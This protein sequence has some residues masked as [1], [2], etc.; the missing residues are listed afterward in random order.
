LHYICN[1]SL[2]FGS[3]FVDF[4]PKY[5]GIR[6]KIGMN[7]MNASVMQGL[8]GA[9][10]FMQSAGAAFTLFNVARTEGDEGKMQ[11]A[12]NFMKSSVGSAMSLS[13]AVAR[14]VEQAQEE[15]ALRAR[16]ELEAAV[17]QS[18]GAA[19]DTVEISAQARIALAVE[20]RTA[21]VSA[22]QAQVDAQA[23]K[24][25]VKSGATVYRANGAVRAVGAS[26][27]P[28]VSVTA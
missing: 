6:R 3:S 22:A 11:G 16:A 21:E 2:F 26:A 25:A 18:A 20:G 24:A 13:E 14:A 12:L 9:N 5:T 23:A 17:S 10:S 8:I 7:L 4:C 27:T 15:E 1:I 28:K 19:G